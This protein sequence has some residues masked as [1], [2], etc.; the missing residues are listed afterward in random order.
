AEL[1]ESQL[2]YPVLAYYRSQH[3][4]QSWVAAL[5]MILDTCALVMAGIEGTSVRQAQLTF[6]M[7]RH[8]AVDLSQIFNAQPA[9]PTPDRLPPDDL[10]EVRGTL[11]AA[12]VSLRA[13]HEAEKKLAHLREMYEPYVN[14]LSDYLLMALPPW[15]PDPEA[16]DA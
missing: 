12:G 11:M 6:A 3:D 14:A 8:A 16:R 5:T 10:E 15:L 7:A 9:M 13:G 2:S 4:H 1:M